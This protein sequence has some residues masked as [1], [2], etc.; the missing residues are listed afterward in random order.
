MIIARFPTQIVR[1][2]KQVVGLLGKFFH[3]GA[4][5]SVHFMA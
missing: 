1:N 5:V 4:V 2:L 3:V